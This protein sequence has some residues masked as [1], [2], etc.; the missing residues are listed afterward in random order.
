MSI[1]PENPAMLLQFFK[2]LAHES[3]LRLLGLVA[4]REH[5][6]QQLA[7]LLALKEPTVS[8]HMAMLREAGLVRLRQDGNT[9]WYGLEQKRLARLSRALLARDQLEMLA[10]PQTQN[11]G[12]DRIVRNYLTAE[13]R[14]KAFP[15]TRKKRRPILAWLARQFEEGRNYSEAE[16]N[17]ILERRH[18]DRETFRRE[19]VGHHMLARQAGIYWRLPETEW[20]A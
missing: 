12:E 5:S 9:H 10:G 2:A 7:E 13:G 3:R 1:E 18:H 11:A 6:V 16:V 8:H 14:L 15:A 19:L 17:E 4:A 20:A